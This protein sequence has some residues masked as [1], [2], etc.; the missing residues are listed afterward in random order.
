MAMH[1]HHEYEHEREVSMTPQTPLRRALGA[2]AALLMLAAAVQTH[3]ETFGRTT[4]GAN[5]SGGLREHYKRGSKFTLSEA[6]TLQ[7]LCAYV[8]GKG[9]G[10]GTS[11]RQYFQILLYN[12]VSGAPGNRVA[13]T[14]DL[15]ILPGAAAEWACTEVALTPLNP[16]N[17][18]IVLFTG[19]DAA[20]GRYYAD[21]TGNWY[22]NTEDFRGRDQSETF[23]PGSFG[24]GTLSVY[25]EYAPLSKLR[26]AGKTTVDSQ[27]AETT[28]GTKRASSFIMPETG[29]VVGMSA[30]LD[31]YAGGDEYQ[32]LRFDVY[33]DANGKPGALVP[34][35]SGY[36][37]KDTHEH[38]EWNGGY[39]AEINTLPAGKYWFS[40]LAGQGGVARYSFDET[41]TLFTNSNYLPDGP[42]NPFGAA[43][44]SVGT[45]SAFVAYEPGPFVIQKFGRTD[46]ASTA[47]SPMSANQLRGS[48]FTAP[49]DNGVLKNA[50]VY[51]DGL[52]GTT[53]AQKMKFILYNESMQIVSLGSEIT[54]PAGMSPQWVK[55][56]L[57]NKPMKA[58][59][60]FLALF[61]G[62]PA[63]V[64]RM[65]GDGANNWYGMSMCYDACGGSPRG[66][67]PSELAAGTRTLSMYAEYEV[68]AN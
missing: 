21:G 65:Y 6:G 4:I 53:G 16:G 48:Y 10:T 55:F 40:I 13:G 42:S 67:Q 51:L 61:S 62:G 35:L 37:A 57:P 49:K 17:Y 9:G 5:P 2:F 68:P 24:D 27:R 54:I 26:V 7:R 39:M 18:W 46:A 38:G 47:L 34:H 31:G 1:L 25:A 12:D 32:E 23:G 66:F 60:Y 22:G 59:R 50:Y 44:A 63:G 3:A 56:P 41:G 33:K 20:V 52:G 30:F 36:T 19:W 28:G 64:A 11:G 15:Q 45:M 8:D 43:S 14:R 29:R 58:G